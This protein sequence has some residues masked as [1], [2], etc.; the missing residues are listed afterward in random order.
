MAIIVPGQ[1]FG[2]CRAPESHGEQEVIHCLRL[3]TK[4]ESSGDETLHLVNI[5]V[6]VYRCIFVIR[7][8]AGM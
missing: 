6:I 3:E 8:L 1:S 4:Q 7:L 5:L 2:C